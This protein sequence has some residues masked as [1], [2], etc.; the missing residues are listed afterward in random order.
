MFK[1]LGGDI[2]LK[3]LLVDDEPYILQGLR[4]LVDWEEEGFKITGMAAN[5]QEALKFLKNNKVDLILADIKMPI[6]NGLELLA[7]IRN[8]DI[9]DA[10]FII[11]SGYADFLFAQEAIRYDCTDYILKPVSKEQL[12][13]TLHKV[14][15]MKVNNP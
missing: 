4:V 15:Y 13:D 7:R 6:M 10:Y 5:G 12:I 1:Y 2:V 11:L 9:S 8:D 3:V 14:K